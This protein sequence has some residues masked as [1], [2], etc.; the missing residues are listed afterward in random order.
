[1]SFFDQLTVWVNEL[2][3]L[4]GNA[5]ATL[6]HNKITLCVIVGTGIY[7]T[8]RLGGIQLMGFRHAT[9]VV[10]GHYSK[11]SDKGEVNHFQA[12]STALSATVGMGNIAGVAVGAP[13]SALVLELLGP[14]APFLLAV[15]IGIMQE[16]VYT[17]SGAESAA[18]GIRGTPF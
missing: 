3:V 5:A 10:R 14:T 12:L 4:T 8:I 11:K 15:V 18:A 17:Q 2:T 6:A 9:K 1:M 16:R 13:V 7:L